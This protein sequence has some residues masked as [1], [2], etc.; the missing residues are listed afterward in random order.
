M[1]EVSID[2]N[3]YQAPEPYMDLERAKTLAQ[4]FYLRARADGMPDDKLEIIRR[5]QDDVEALIEKRDEQA[6][7]MQMGAMPGAEALPGEQLGEA[8]GQPAAPAV[9]ELL[10]AQ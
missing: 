6:Q 7:A 5:Y 8:T 3:K 2:Q 10:P 9:S 1:L 4:S